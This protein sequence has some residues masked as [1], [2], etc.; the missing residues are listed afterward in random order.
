MS[1]GTEDKIRWICAPCG[2]RH[3]VKQ[4]NN[5]TAYTGMDCSWCRA[6]DKVVYRP[7]SYGIPVRNPQMEMDV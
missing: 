2:D 1:A 4:K 6:E 7:D 3:G 5:A